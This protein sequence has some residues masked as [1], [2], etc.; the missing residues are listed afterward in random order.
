[1]KLTPRMSASVSGFG[2]E[3]LPQAVQVQA[4]SGTGDTTWS[5]QVKGIESGEHTL[6]FRLAGTLIVE[7]KEIGRDFYQYQQ[8]VNVSVGPGGFLK[9]NWQWP[10]STIALSAIGV[11]WGLLRSRKFPAPP[12]ERSVADRIC[13]RR[14]LRASI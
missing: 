9:D 2:F 10:A 3:I 12:P 7:G 6:T 13:G 1:M 11:A 8:K 5:W 4:V 14:Q